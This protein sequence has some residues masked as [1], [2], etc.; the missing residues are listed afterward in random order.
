MIATVFNISNTEIIGYI[1]SV[2]V[3]TSFLMRDIKKLRI[4][5]IIGSSTFIVYGV[6]LDFSIPI[7]LTNTCIVGIN[8]FYLVKEN[9]A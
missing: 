3:L 9:K 2:L 1:G 5:N 6:L 8:A 4:G 7:I